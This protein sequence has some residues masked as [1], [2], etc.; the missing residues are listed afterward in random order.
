[1]AQS[2]TND[3]GQ[4]GQFTSPSHLDT[5]HLLSSTSALVVPPPTP[6]ATVTTPASSTRAYPVHVD[7]Q[8][9]HRSGRAVVHSG[10]G[11]DGSVGGLQVDVPGSSATPA[12]PIASPAVNATSSDAAL[13]LS[14]WLAD[15]LSAGTAAALVPSPALSTTLTR[16]PLLAF[17]NNHAPSTR[18]SGANPDSTATAP[19]YRSENEHPISNEAE[20]SI[21]P[22]ST[23]LTPSTN[24]ATSAATVTSLVANAACT[25]AAAALSSWVADF[26]SAGSSSAAT[27]P[28][29]APTSIILPPPTHA[30]TPISAFNNDGVPSAHNSSPRSDDASAAQVDAS[31][32]KHPE[33]H[34]VYAPATDAESITIRPTWTPLTPDA[35]PAPSVNA[36]N[37]HDDSITDT[38][39]EDSDDYDPMDVDLTRPVDPRRLTYIAEVLVLDDN[40]VLDAYTS[41]DTDL[42][43]EIVQV[44]RAAHISGGTLLLARPQTNNPEDHHHED[45]DDEDMALTSLSSSPRSH[46]PVTVSDL[47][48]DLAYPYDGP[49]DTYPTVHAVVVASGSRSSPSRADSNMSIDGLEVSQFE[50]SPHGQATAVTPAAS[51]RQ[52]LSAL[53]GLRDNV[54]AKYDSAL[55]TILRG[56]YAIC[57]KA[58]VQVRRARNL[59]LDRWLATQ[60]GANN[61]DTHRALLTRH[62]LFDLKFGSA[63]NPLLFPVEEREI[64]QALNFFR[65]RRDPRLALE[66]ECLQAILDFRLPTEITEHITRLRDAGALGGTWAANFIL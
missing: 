66:L 63:G 65:Q 58:G 34:F 55:D 1:A 31:D 62:A 57:N 17:N 15:L 54:V 40:R 35:T 6:N 46:S 42:L 41:D 5:A 30:R 10:E 48:D 44:C 26:F 22:G 2:L 45:H 4:N 8:E 3:G 25:D 39:S 49:L 9:Y 21:Q 20:P 32:D 28:S 19:R 37:G 24:P 18:I 51:Q 60:D 27:I 50:T 64:S 56:R 29:S 12:A 16:T 61:S 53:L 52:F 43:E 7:G 33:I 59:G 23:P 11:E 38:G 36:S 47:P 13:A 14:T